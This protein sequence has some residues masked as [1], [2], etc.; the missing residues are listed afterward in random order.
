[1]IKTFE[2]FLKHAKELRRKSFLADT[3]LLLFLVKFEQSRTYET[4]GFSTFTRCLVVYRLASPAR[5]ADFKRGLAVVPGKDVATVGVHAVV[6]AGKLRAPS[7]RREFLDAA[8]LKVEQDGF[9]FSE[10]ASRNERQRLEA[11]PGYQPALVRNE[12]RAVGRVA[13]LEALVAKLR[14]GIG[15]RD[16][17]I[18]KLLADIRER[19]ARIKELEEKK[20]KARVATRSAADGGEDAHA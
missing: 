6:D 8:A 17:R 5:F 12:T 4:A 7:K 19:D 13:E 20:T 1:M 14:A 16:A 9:P 15:E 10:Q 3:E 18:T 11:K 2:Q